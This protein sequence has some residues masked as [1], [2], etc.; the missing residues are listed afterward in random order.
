MDLIECRSMD[1]D[2]R[3][4][5]QRLGAHSFEAPDQGLDFTRRLAREQGWTLAQARQAVDEY[6]KFCFLACSGAGEMTPSREVDEVWHLHLIHTRDYWHEFCPKVLGMDLHHGP[7]RGGHSEARR[8]GEQYAHTL[9]CYEQWFGPPPETWWPGTAARFAPQLLPRQTGPGKPRRWLALA[10]LGAGGLCLARLA[11]AQSANPLDWTGGEFL[12]LYLV[13]TLCV[14]VA[15]VLIRRAARDTG[16]ARGARPEALELAYLAGGAT[17]CADAGIAQMLAEGQ[18]EW[19]AAATKLRST[20][21]ARRLGEP[22]EQIAQCIAADG[23][24]DRAV[25]R[26]ALR[27]D[28]VRKALVAKGL[29][30]DDAGAWRARWWSALPWLLLAGFGAAKILVGISR[31][32]PVAFLVIL[33]II[34]TVVGLI[35]LLKRPGRTRAGDRAIAE[36][37]VQHA[38]AIRAPRAQ[39]AGLAVALLGTAALSGTAW[40]SYHQSRMPPS[41]SS[42]DSGSSGSDS[43]SSD[44]GGDSGGGGCGGCGGGGGD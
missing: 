30:L 33:S 25:S 22:F 42:S 5:W 38:R 26:A 41:S 43:G 19:D 20:G 34:T 14:L 1:G 6:R 27:L 17:R 2:Q 11:Q 21:G 24:P 32:K 39:E 10:S 15:S 44:S 36:A 9:A 31:G 28:N 16:A 13:A 3:A 8:H 4:R 23:E 12:K 37:R 18:V 29:W 40:A 7:T 35:L